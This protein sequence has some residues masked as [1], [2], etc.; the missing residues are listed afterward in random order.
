MQD[1]YIHQNRVRQ[2]FFLIC[3]V[4]LFLLLARQL[5]GFVPALLGAITLYI[6]MKKPLNY[7]VINKKWPKTLTVWLFMIG[8]FLVILM[9]LVS[10]A[11]M[12]TSKVTYGIEH[13]NE[14][15]ESLRSIVRQL[16]SQTGFEI[17]NSE[18]LNKLGSW[19]S[20]AIP[21]LIGATFGTLGTLF[22]MY[23][24]LYFMLINYG[25]LEK[26]LH[27]YIPLKEENIVLLG[28]EIQNMVMSNAIGIPVI[29][30]LQGVVALIS[31]FILGVKEPMF[32]FVVT[33]FTAML[34]V[35]GAALA[36]VPI[37]IIFFANSQIWQ[38]IVMLIYGFGVV[39]T[40][41]NIFR[42][43]LA[44]KL[45]NIHPL[46][47]VFGVIIGLK[48][49]GFLGLIFGPL[50]ISLFILLLRIYSSEFKVATEK[51]NT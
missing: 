17:V 4:L 8:S 41:D 34:P 31:Y 6:L 47:T 20:K 39:G 48:L 51:A 14:F 26:D 45:G 25:E 38:G 16:E 11:G 15:V 50:L 9:P 5:A 3:I 40:V 2:L 32:W 46:I 27:K 12:L 24:I 42:F 10:L 19:V 36:Y 35:L 43:T 29:A 49:F 28:K 33:C 22:F 30:F 1:H 37:A 23:F 18:L 7:L 21:Q 13:S 44:R